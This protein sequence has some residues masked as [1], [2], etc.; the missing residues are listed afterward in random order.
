MNQDVRYQCTATPRQAGRGRA[1]GPS[2]VGPAR[3]QRGRG[4]CGRRCVPFSDECRRHRRPGTADAGAVKGRRV[5]WVVSERHCRRHRTGGGGRGGH[6]RWFRLR[7]V[8]DA[9]PGGRRRGRGRTFSPSAALPLPRAPL[10]GSPKWTRHAERSASDTSSAPG[11]GA[12]ARR[13]PTSPSRSRTTLPGAWRNG[14][15]VFPFH[16]GHRSRT[17]FGRRKD[18]GQV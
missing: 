11:P 4:G 3:S 2:G 15:S 13:S 10:R 8:K 1:T 12:R 17:W 9:G 16:G 5:G 18:P 14:G 7:R 6:R